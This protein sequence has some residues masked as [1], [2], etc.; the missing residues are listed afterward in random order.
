MA[1][2]IVFVAGTDPLQRLGGHSAYVRTHGLAARRAGFAPTIL[3]VG[4]GPTLIEAEF[5]DVHRIP[6]R[7]EPERLVRFRQHQ[8][9]W[10]FPMLRRAVEAFV[11]AHP[12]NRLIHG[13]GVFSGVAAQASQAL[14]RRGLATVTVASAYDTMARE[15][16]A[17]LS[18]LGPDYTCL[19]RLQHAAELFWV[20]LAIDRW[21]RQGYRDARL[22]LV[23]YDSVRRLL[24]ASY[25]LGDTIRHIPYSAEAAF[26]E[27]LTPAPWPEARSRNTLEGTPLVVAVSRHDARKGIGVLLRALGRL[28]EA[29]VAFRASLLGT[30]PLLAAHLRLAD[31]LGLSDVITIHGHVPDPYPFLERADVF[32]L[33]SL[34]EGSGSLA[35]LEALQAGVA[36][37][38][39][40]VDGIL[41]DVVDGES[42]A[43]VPP[44][45]I[46]A[47]QATL[48]RLLG[49][50][51]LRARLGAAGRSL[52]ERRFS[53]DAFTAALAAVYAEIGVH[54]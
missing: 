52:F 48:A 5:G 40:A 38:A 2:P 19:T 32:V 13:F 18:G 7:W 33:P 28:R 26:R 31:Q 37:V 51:A 50:P 10:R 16:R 25:G 53:A 44:G 34:T 15:V 27:P 46:V 22:V 45:D 29:G 30:G 3:C 23:N 8:L 42:A 54:P 41:E 47:L 35:L 21:E 43:L 14:R 6:T 20:R 49:D 17:K 36:V 12:R 9:A 4:Q 11:A 1:Q 39:S 24:T